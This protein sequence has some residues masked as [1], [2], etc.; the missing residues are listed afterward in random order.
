M[1]ELINPT[2]PDAFVGIDPDDTITIEFDK[3]KFTLGVLPVGLWDRFAARSF[4]AVQHARRVTIKRLA[5]EGKNPE[6]LVGETATLLDIELQR[7]DTYRAE[8]HRVWVDAVRY[9]LRGHEK[10]NTKAGKPVPFLTETK[11]IDG[12]ELQVVTETTLKHYRPNMILM[13]AL[14]GG[15]RQLHTIGVPEKKA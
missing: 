2:E 6:E 11:I 8:Q 15:L 1:E 3:G 7:D 10:F 9:G 14:W 12:V 13:V 4:V 5:E